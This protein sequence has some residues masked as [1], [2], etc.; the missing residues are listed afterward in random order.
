VQRRQRRAQ[1]PPGSANTPTRLSA[2]G[3]ARGSRASPSFSGP[4][5]V[6]DHLLLLLLKHLVVQHLLIIDHLLVVDR[7]LKVVLILLP[8][9]HVV[10]R[11]RRRGRGPTSDPE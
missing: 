7:L 9:N 11:R 1:L 2:V 10:H 8:S 4:L 3:H 6:V 5:L